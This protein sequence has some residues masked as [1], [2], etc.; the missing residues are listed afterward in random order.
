MFRGL[1][2]GMNDM[3][4]Y[5]SIVS[6]PAYVNEGAMA[7]SDLILPMRRASGYSAVDPVQEAERICEQ[8]NARFTYMRR[9]VFE[10]LCEA[11]RPLGAYD[12]MERLSRVLNKHL[13]PPTVYRALEF[14]L[15]HRL[16]ARIESRNAFVPNTDPSHRNA[17]VFFICMHCGSAAEMEDSAIAKLLRKDAATLGF[18]I[19][20]QVVELQGTCANCRDD[21]HRQASTN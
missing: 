21:D 9:A 18:E 10:V 20:K 5:Y 8:R 19:G 4:Y 14:L 1:V 16:I 7:D 6:E 2:A 3:L 13:G 11:G 17:G 15:K 12:I